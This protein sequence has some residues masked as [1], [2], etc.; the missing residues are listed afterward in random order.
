[1]RFFYI[2]E[3][4]LQHLETNLENSV[5]INNNYGVLLKQNSFINN[6]SINNGQLTIDDSATLDV[7]NNI[8]LTNKKI[9]INITSGQYGKIVSAGEISVN[10]SSKIKFDYSKTI[11]ANLDITGQTKYDI[12]VASNTISNVD[13]ILVEDN[14]LLYDN[15]ITSS[16]NKVVTNLVKSSQFQESVL[17]KEK[18]DSLQGLIDLQNSKIKDGIGYV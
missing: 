12:L 7:T 18:Y 14:S 8:D 3:I 16:S 10:D 4:N 5:I 2:L 15:Q 17:G 13:K 1:M 6:L 11:G 9:G